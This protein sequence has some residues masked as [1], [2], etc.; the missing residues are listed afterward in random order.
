MVEVVRC[1]SG[2]GTEGKRSRPRLGQVNLRPP[3]TSAHQNCSHQLSLTCLPHFGMSTIRNT[4]DV[5]FNDRRIHEPL[6]ASVR[7]LVVAPAAHL[8][9]SQ[10]G[11]LSE[12]R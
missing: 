9:A 5:L 4:K 10:I 11:S 7:Y 3:K 8:I 1:S 6:R 2:V 12:Y